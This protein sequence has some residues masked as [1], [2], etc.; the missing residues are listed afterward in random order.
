MAQLVWADFIGEIA[1]LKADGS[2]DAWVALD[3]PANGTATLSTTEGDVLEARD[4][5]NAIV[6]SITRANDFSLVLNMFKKAGKTKPIADVNG[7][8]A[9]E[10]A[11]R[12]VGIDPTAGGYQMLRCSV[13]VQE[14]FTVSDG[15]QWIYTF[16]GKVPPSGTIVQ[17]Y[18]PS[19][20]GGS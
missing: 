18:M 5:S 17:D 7:V 19:G 12:W 10:Y 1:P 8:V 3:R 20:G 2:P 6:D 16:R 11:I 13:S 4:E 15:G 14:S 9:K